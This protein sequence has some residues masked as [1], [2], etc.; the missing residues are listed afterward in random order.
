MTRGGLTRRRGTKRRG[1]PSPCRE[2]VRSR[3]LQKK[4]PIE[5]GKN[6]D[7]FSRRRLDRLVNSHCLQHLT[8]WIRSVWSQ[9]SVSKFCIVRDSI[10]HHRH[11]LLR[12]GGLC[13]WC[14]SCTKYRRRGPALG[15]KKLPNSNN[16]L[17]PVSCW[18]ASCTFSRN[19][20]TATFMIAVIFSCQLLV[21]I[22]VPTLYLSTVWTTF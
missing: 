3:V 22:V 21:T 16:G 2:A 7:S 8:H 13:V 5:Q 14:Q 19:S 4:E 1:E 18:S 9:V 17:S 11:V 6:L 15:E 20:H 10:V 12:I